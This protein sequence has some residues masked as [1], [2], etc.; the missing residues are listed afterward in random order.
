MDKEVAREVVG[1]MTESLREA[2]RITDEVALEIG[3]CRLNSLQSKLN[4]LLEELDNM[5]NMLD[6]LEAIGATEEIEP[7]QVR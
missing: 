1:D 2:K 5:A 4:R 6:L 3:D 7:D